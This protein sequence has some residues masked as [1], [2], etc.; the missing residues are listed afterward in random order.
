MDLGELIESAEPIINRLDYK[1]GAVEFAVELRRCG[2]DDLTEIRKKCTDK[3]VTKQPDGSK[4]WESR[5]NETRLNAYLAKHCLVG[6]E[7]VTVDMAIALCNLKLPD[8]KQELGAK[9]L[10]FS[11][12]NA[13]SLLNGALGF[14]GWV[15]E[16][17]TS[18][19]ED[20]EDE[21]DREK[22]SSAPTSEDTS[23]L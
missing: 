5:L 9:V 10:P 1:A 14:A 19:A 8:G 22:P 7:G 18:L 16:Q 23:A 3:V 4:V 6:W 11:E 21:A 2:R 13:L 15:L 12:G 20:R 17:A